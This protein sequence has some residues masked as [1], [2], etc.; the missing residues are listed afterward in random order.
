MNNKN[1]IYKVTSPSGRVYIGQTINLKRRLKEYR[2]LKCD[3]QPRLYNS[4]KKHG[5]D[6]HKIEILEY[7]KEEELNDRERYYQDFYN[8]L[9]RKGLNCRLTSSDDKSGRLSE[10]TI[11]KLKSKDFSY[12]VGNDFRTGIKHSEEIKNKIRNTL[13]ENAKKPDYVNGMTGRSGELNPFYGKTHSEETKNILRKK[14][15][16]N[17]KQIEILTS[18][19]LKR[20]QLL[21]HTS[22]GIYYESIR[23]A[24]ICLDINYSTLKA[25]LLG[26]FR[27]NSNLIKV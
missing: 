5:F 17:K 22:T 19:C 2:T 9:S 1:V 7:C 14:A 6:K 12:M 24:S 16:S 15:A 18:Y 25:M 21:L 27:N 4:F 23:E 8:V 3:T 26:Y 11:K 10:E 20:R 13:I